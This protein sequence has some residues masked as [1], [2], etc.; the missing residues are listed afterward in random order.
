MTTWWEDF[1]AAEPEFAQEVRA[2][3]A[4]RKH[5][6]M[7][8]LR[9]DGSPRIS[10]TEFDFTDGGLYLGSMPGARKALDLIR[11]PRVALHSPTEDSPQDAT[12]WPGDAKISGRAHDVTEPDQSAEAHRF[13]IEV[14][15][16]TLTRIAPSGDRLLVR[17]WHPGRGLETVTRA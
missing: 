12:A 16:V 14:L 6:T 7:A 5:G 8:S 9:R 1:A 11:D 17:T 10:G 3:F 15:E 2:R 13:R 4:V